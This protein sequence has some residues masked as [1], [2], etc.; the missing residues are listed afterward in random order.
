[1]R[2]DHDLAFMLQYE[3]IAWYEDGK[4][5]I[6]D[7]RVYP[8]KVEFVTCCSHTEVAQAITDMVTQ[9]AGPYTAVPMGMALAAYECRDKS[10]AEQM[11]Y[12]RKAAYTISHARPTTVK[13]MALLCDLCLA[14]AERALAAGENA[15]EA[16]KSKT[17]ELNNVRYSRMA[18]IG[19]YLVDMFPENGTVMTHCFAETIV[20]MMLR[21]CSER[22][23]H[24]RLFCPET[25]PYF[26][27]ARLTA[28]VC[29]DMG[30]DVTVISDNMPA[31]V[32]RRRRSM[33]LPPLPTPSAA[34]AMWSTRLAPSR[35]PSSQSTWAFRTL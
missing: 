27:G 1:M 35:T 4:V 32:M 19:K 17:I 10:A 18:T 26:Q 7:R 21:E 13:R 34:T 6:L 11:E 22:G 31:F 5:N 3:N 9:S 14:E 16:I 8:A 25:R 2:A 12:L 15:A 20:G 29:R 23:K 28:T 33:S 24:I 30:F